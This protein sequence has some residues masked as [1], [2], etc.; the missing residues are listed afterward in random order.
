MD[1]DKTTEDILTRT[2][3]RN[4]EIEKLLNATENES[5]LKRND[6]DKSANST[7]FSS[8]TP[9][10]PITNY[11]CS[12]PESSSPTKRHSK[13]A[14]L[15]AIVDEFEY[16]YKPNSSRSKEEL[17]K[18]PQK[19]IS[20]GGETRPSVLF[21]PNRYS[22]AENKSPRKQGDETLLSNKPAQMSGEKSN[23]DTV[24]IE[25]W[26]DSPKSKNV[27][28]VTLREKTDVESEK[29]ERRS[30]FAALSAHFSEFEYEAKSEKVSPIKKSM[31][32]FEDKNIPFVDNES[33]PNVHDSSSELYGIH[34]FGEKTLTQN[35][36]AKM[37]ESPAIN[38]S[39]AFVCK[40]DEGQSNNTKIES[41]KLS[42]I[43]H[44]PQRDTNSRSE[45]LDSG[46]LKDV[47]E[48]TPTCNVKLPE[49]I[50]AQSPPD[51]NT[52]PRSAVVK[53]PLSSVK[54]LRNRWEVSSATGTPLHPNQDNDELLDAA[55][56]MVKSNDRPKKPFKRNFKSSDVQSEFFNNDN[57]SGNSEGQSEIAPQNAEEGDISPKKQL[58]TSCPQAFSD[59][60]N[61][62]KESAV[63][64]I[65]QAFDF[66]PSES[67]MTPVKP[68]NDD[69]KKVQYQKTG[70]FRAVTP[71][72]EIVGSLMEAI[73]EDFEKNYTP[74]SR[75]IAKQAFEEDEIDYRPLEKN[76]LAHTISF[77]RRQGTLARK[78]QI[79][80]KTE[81]D[82]KSD[83][84][85]NASADQTDSSA[86]PYA[87][88]NEATL[89]RLHEAIIVQ[90]DQICQ[91]S[92]ALAFCRQN[93]HFRGSREEVDA[94]RALLI[95]T[96][97]RRAY[98]VERD[99]IMNSRGLVI[100]NERASEPR[101]TLTF[102]YM[103][104]KLSRDYINMYVRSHSECYQYYF[105]VLI[106]HGENVLHTSLASSSQGVKSGFVEFS[107]YIQLCGLTTDFTCT[108]EIYA[109]RTA[110][111][112]KGQ[113][114]AKKQSTWKRMVT[115]PISGSLLSHSAGSATLPGSSSRPVCVIDPGFQ[116]VGYVTLNRS[117]IKKQKFYMTDAME[118][119][120]GNLVLNMR[121]FAEEVDP[122]EMRG[123]ISLY[124]IVSGLGAWTRFWCVLNNG[125]MRFW[126][127]LEDEEKKSPSVTL[128][129]SKCLSN[130][131]EVSPSVASLPH[132]IQV[133]VA[134]G[135]EEMPTEEIRLLL[136]AESHEMKL[137]W[138]EVINT[139]IRNAH[140]WE[141][142]QNK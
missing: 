91:A 28:N 117:Q 66:I 78:T 75:R 136:A 97:R 7:H 58:K 67:H 72:S 10:T 6:T 130:V 15:S 141:S 105:I 4:A 49:S 103:A 21:T 40:K 5:D 80:L 9:L 90:Q 64:I 104:V 24:I 88:T 8:E 37:C 82:D 96:E 84:E 139:A 99:R 129:L 12:G 65:D 57:G 135:D 68:T 110:F 95:A 138:T 86:P 29:P 93:T 107:H 46:K 112:E 54:T 127:Y 101:G 16:D 87:P 62:N 126:R 30:R 60:S 35:V 85:E 27:E 111:E 120:D 76:S 55:M 53:T 79:D 89:K 77:Y 63:E 31:R 83:N 109:L 25:E 142:A 131:S 38:S 100:S 69:L 23:V 26:D 128:D 11:A 52:S 36:R 113:D 17:V 41:I 137:R 13:F 14:Q 81:D 33:S 94:Q 45:I 32:L 71:N 108:V 133:D 106:K 34:T 42:A 51:N 19:R 22:I 1:E 123:F 114:K 59:A 125:Q 3:L 18:G 56:R 134:L 124:Q 121:C 20:M 74:K 119:L 2:R 118:P 115:T 39:N 92:R 73:N 98:V 48:K 61:E 122:L 132:S 44:S 50:K 47:Q 102:S 70:P 116:K 140:L 43:M